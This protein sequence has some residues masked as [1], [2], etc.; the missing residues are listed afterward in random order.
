MTHVVRQNLQR[1]QRKLAKQED[2]L[3]NA[4]NMEQYRLF[5]ELLTVHQHAVRKGMQFVMLSNYYEPDGAEVKIP[6][7]PAKSAM[8]N[9]QSY[10][11]RY[12]KA[13]V[14]SNLVLQQIE[15]NEEE[16][17]YLSDLELS[18]T[19]C[20]S[21]SEV[22]EI[23]EELIKAGYLRPGKVK[24]VK[25][26]PPSRPLHFISSDGYDIYVGRNNHQNDQLTLKTARKDDMWL[27]TQKIPGSHVIIKAQD[28]EIS[29]QALGEAALLAAHFSKASE[30]SQ[31]PVD[32]TRKTNVKKPAGAKPGF[33]VYTPH[34][35]LYVSPQGDRMT[36]IL[37]RQEGKT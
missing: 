34:Q 1:C 33:V 36:D 31:V 6:L 11:T 25:S 7:D 22:Q 21:E 19:Q 24:G 13:Q 12:R 8:E 4:E 37:A 5:G 16:I 3:N 26:L 2:A 30:S 32:F 15:E 18:L 27:H 10:Y 35:T 28:G 29:S 9:A 17:R 23:H 14:A 20:G